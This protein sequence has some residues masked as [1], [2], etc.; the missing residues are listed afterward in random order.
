MSNITPV[1]IEYIS[2]IGDHILKAEVE[3]LELARRFSFYF[4]DKLVS[5]KAVGPG[6]FFTDDDCISDMVKNYCQNNKGVLSDLFAN[7]SD[8]IHLIEKNL[9]FVIEHFGIKMKAYVVE[10]KEQYKISV[11]AENNVDEFSC[12]IKACNFS[13]VLEKVRI[14]TSTLV[15]ISDNFS[16]NIDELAN[17]KVEAW[18]KWE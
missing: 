3:H 16:S 12:T 18:I 2:E 13:E 1:N 5:E 9:E 10:E 4:D 7:H 14:F 17:D 11:K 6:E 8:K 15:N